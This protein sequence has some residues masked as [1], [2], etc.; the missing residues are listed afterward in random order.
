MHQ[1]QFMQE[2]LLHYYLVWMLGTTTWA[3]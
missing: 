2:Y 1:V 3:K